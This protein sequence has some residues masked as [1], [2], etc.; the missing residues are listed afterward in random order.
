MSWLSKERMAQIAKESF[1]EEHL[2]YPPIGGYHQAKA[3]SE[4]QFRLKASEWFKKSQPSTK[5]RELT[6]AFG[7]IAFEEIYNHF[8]EGRSI[9]V[10]Q[11]GKL[12]EIQPPKDGIRLV[13]YIPNFNLTTWPLIEDKLGRKLS[14]EE[15]EQYFYTSGMRKEWLF[16][17]IRECQSPSEAEELFRQAQLPMSE[18][19]G[20]NKY[21]KPEPKK[22][23]LSR[24]FNFIFGK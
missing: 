22:N 15:N 10:W 1:E 21:P 20:W 11:D 3:N 23:I 19:F 13:D 7:T 24:I 14:K 8:K 4:R 2:D 12:V 16:N 18:F 17:R 5:A 9:S 6:Q